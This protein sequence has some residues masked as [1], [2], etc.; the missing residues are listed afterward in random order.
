MAQKNRIDLGATILANLP[1]NTSNYI[2]PLLHREVEDDLKDSNYNI[3]DDDASVVAYTPDTPSDWDVV[4]T[5]LQSSTDELASRVR[6]LEGTSNFVLTTFIGHT[7]STVPAS[8]PVIGVVAANTLSQFLD[9]NTAS[10]TWEYRTG[11]GDTWISAGTVA[12]LN[13]ALVGINTLPT[14]QTAVRPTLT[15][16]GT[17]EGQLSVTLKNIN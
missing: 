16:V 4:P 3:L 14:S 1:N 17:W 10:A 2:T 13:T 8:Q 12:Q 9:A 5:E 15:R 7:D 11:A 6:T